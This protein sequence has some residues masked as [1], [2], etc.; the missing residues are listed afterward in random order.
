MSLEG[1]DAKKKMKSLLKENTI[2]SDRKLKVPIYKYKQRND[3]YLITEVFLDTAF[4]VCE[5]N[6]V[7]TSRDVGRL[8][9]TA[10]FAAFE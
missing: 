5:E 2:E 4:P 3:R 6:T 7:A 9:G 1:E 10:L 8:R